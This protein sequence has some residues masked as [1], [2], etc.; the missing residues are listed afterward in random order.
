M[1]THCEGR[2]ANRQGRLEYREGTFLNLQG[3]LIHREGTPANRQGTLNHLKCA[4]ISNFSGLGRFLGEM[5][6]EWEGNKMVPS[7]VT[8]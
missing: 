8:E 1:L 3:A 2:L 7:L 5:V 4:K 6:A